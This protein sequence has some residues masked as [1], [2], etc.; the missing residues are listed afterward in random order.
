MSYTDIFGRTLD[1]LHIDMPSNDLEQFMQQNHTT[2]EVVARLGIGDH[3]QYDADN[4]KD[5]SDNDMNLA[6]V[7]SGQRDAIT[8]YER[9]KL[10]EIA[11]GMDEIDNA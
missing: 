7:R 10:K 2:A 3:T 9:D 11:K 5:F 8:I 1:N 4:T 6:S